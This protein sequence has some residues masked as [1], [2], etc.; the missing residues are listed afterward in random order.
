MANNVAALLDPKS[1]VLKPGD[2]DTAI[3]YSI[4]TAQRGL[5]GISFGGFLIKR[6]ADLL[7]AELRGLKTFATLSP[8]PGFRTWLDPPLEAGG[9]QIGRASWRERVCQYV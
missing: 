3:F 2:A 6:V 9:D 1:P 5:V 8:I 4:S 7:A